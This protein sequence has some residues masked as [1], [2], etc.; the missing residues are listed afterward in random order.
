[1][2][3]L[4]DSKVGDKVWSF[5]TGYGVIIEISKGDDFPVIVES[6]DGTQ[7]S[8][9]YDCRYRFQDLNTEL[10]HSE[11]EFEELDYQEITFET[12]KPE[13]LAGL[14]PALGDTQ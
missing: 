9:T 11:V 2:N 6:T 5:H 13:L 3:T 10:F 8:F 14:V 4:K 1:M 7:H 12:G